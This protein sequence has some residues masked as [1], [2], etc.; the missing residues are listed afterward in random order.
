MLACNDMARL[1]G[2]R[3]ERRSKFKG[4]VSAYCVCVSVNV[5]AVHRLSDMRL[6]FGRLV[7]GLGRALCKYDWKGAG[8]V[9]C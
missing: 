8:F 3:E 1:K 6:V 5:I 2:T 7:P 4:R 9:A